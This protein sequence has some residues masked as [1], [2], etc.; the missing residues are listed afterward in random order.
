MNNLWKKETNQ[1]DALYVNLFISVQDDIAYK[2][3]HLLNSFRF[4][5][6]NSQSTKLRMQGN[7]KFRLD[8]W[9]EAMDL[10]NRSLCY[11]EVGT[12]NV[13]L[14]YANR[15][16]CFF[17][18]KMYDESL[19]D[20]VMA[21]KANISKHLIPKLEHRERLCHQ[22]RG[23]VKT[24]SN[25]LCKLSYESDTKFPCMAN[26]IK[27]NY[28]QDFGR[29]L[30]AQQDTPA[31]QTILLEDSYVIARE[32]GKLVCQTCYRA[33][34]NFIACERCPDT[35]FCNTK[36]MNRNPTHKWECGTFFGMVKIDIKFQ[37]RAVLI[38]IDTFGKVEELMN[39]V[40]STPREDPQKLVTSLHN[41]KLKYHFFFKLQ[42]LEPISSELLLDIGTLY[43][44]VI[45]F[46]KIGALFNT[47]KK[48]R[49]LMHLVAH[50]S[51]VTA[52]NSIGNSSNITITNIHS[53]LSHSCAPNVL[54][55]PAG[56]Q[57]FT[58]TIRQV[59][60]GEQLFMNYLHSI[61]D[62]PLKIRQMKL[63]SKWGFVCKCELCIWGDTPPKIKRM[64]NDPYTRFILI[65][66]SIEEYHPVVLESALKLLEKYKDQ[67]WTLEMQ[68]IASILSRIYKKMFSY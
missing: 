62:S 15:S 8:Q 11:A 61:D 7:F 3:A 29:H 33:N 4:G 56:N 60:K 21:K 22:L 58:M 14:A 17:Y 24:P 64:M 53:L 41:A 28:N 54:N 34:A 13:P 23:T 45:E 43:R 32:D 52:N 35:I 59:K 16:A 10:Y 25:D 66:Y 5:K 26:V 49:F 2:S 38:A 42:K 30:I 47:V 57:R 20:I 51:L 44:S 40:E 19:A 50:H 31:G 68:I 18:M 63:K 27:I 12:N 9:P 46:P 1:A 65:N 6:N 36:C 55:Y 67:A 39:F 48:Q 37:I